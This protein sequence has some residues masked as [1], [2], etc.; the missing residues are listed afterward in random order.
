[1]RIIE[2]VNEMR[3]AAA[4]RL[5][6]GVKCGLVPTMG[7]LHQ[8]HLSLMERS[9]EENESTIV[10]VFV[11]PTQFMPGED[12]DSY[13]RT[14]NEDL[15][16]A[17][18]MGVD[19]VF[20]PSAEQ[21]YLPR[22]QTTV[23]VHELTKTLCG[24]SR[25]QGH[26]IGVTT[27]VAKLF[28]LVRPDRA[29]F[30]QKD[31]QQA[32]VIQRMVIDLNFPVEIVVCPIVREEDGLAMSS[33]NR[34]LPPELRERALALRE[35]LVLGREMIQSK[36]YNANTLFNAMCEQILQDN[37][38]EV[39]YLHIV[40]PETLQDVEKVDDLVL[41]AG[42]IRIGGVRLIDNI[43]VGPDGPWQD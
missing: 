22:R 11:N 9:V 17:E 2:D 10:S 30:G 34:N 25:G 7:A 4:E 24:M 40:S 14:W 33:R 29:Y 39:D 21:M 18:R 5:R 43:L 19:I 20:H 12:Y 1:M 37:D 28:N 41:I 26:F 35:A 27:V 8:G 13:P 15:A 42:A 16:A 38:I 6:S 23:Q 31:A 3:E 36:E 32:L